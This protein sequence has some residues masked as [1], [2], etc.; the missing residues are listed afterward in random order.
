MEIRQL[1]CVGY[2]NKEKLKLA[3]RMY[4]VVLEEKTY[5]IDFDIPVNREDF[6]ITC[7]PNFV[8]IENIKEIQF[9]MIVQTEGIYNMKRLENDIDFIDMITPI[10]KRYILN[11]KFHI[12][13]KLNKEAYEILVAS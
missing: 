2:C 1:W 6:T 3:F 4:D 11:K 9:K 5:T 8:V 7:H 13:F 10:I 12:N